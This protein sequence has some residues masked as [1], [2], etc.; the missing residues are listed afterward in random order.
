MN[1]NHSL[2]P[3]DRSN[4]LGT[5]TGGKFRQSMNRDHDVKHCHIGLIRN[6]LR[7]CRLSDNTHLLIKRTM[8][9]PNNNSNGGVLN[10]FC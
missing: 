9:S 1:W 3:I 7:V 2:F 10:I 5:V 8:K 6:C 4:Q